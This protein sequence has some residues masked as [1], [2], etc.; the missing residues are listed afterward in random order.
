MLTTIFGLKLLSVGGDQPFWVDQPN[1]KVG[2][3]YPKK[4]HHPKGM[5]FTHGGKSPSAEG[6][7]WFQK[8]PLK[9]QLLF[10]LN[11]VVCSISLPRNY[12]GIYT[13]RKP[14]NPQNFTG[15]FFFSP[16]MCESILICKNISME[17]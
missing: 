13:H 5:F 12:L 8:P 16:C 15:A 2:Q 14:K 17:G 7:Y 11:H 10:L 1:S 3:H 9:Y 4:I 6:G